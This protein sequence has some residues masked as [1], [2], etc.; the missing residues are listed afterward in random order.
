MDAITIIIIIDISSTAMASSMV[1]IFKNK[2]DSTVDQIYIH[3]YPT[4]HISSD[5]NHA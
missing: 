5:K 1:A 3:L 4:A 2:Q